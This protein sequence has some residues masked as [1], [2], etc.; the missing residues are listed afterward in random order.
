M[1]VR[2]AVLLCAVSSLA[3]ATPSL[4]HDA[5]EVISQGATD[6]DAH[7]VLIDDRYAALE[8][9]AV[10]HIGSYEGEW[11]GE[12]QSE[13][14]YTGDWHG[15]Y[16]AGEASSSLSTEEYSPFGYS[17]EERA[18]WISQCRAL[19]SDGHRYANIEDDDGDGGIIGGLLGAIAGGI[20]GNRVADGER[21]AG[22]LIGAGVGGLAGAVIGSALDQ[23]DDEVVYTEGEHGFDYCEAYL[24]NYE[25]GYGLPQPAISHTAIVTM[26]PMHGAHGHR[27]TA[28][29]HPQQTYTTMQT[30]TRQYVVVEE[31]EVEVEAEAEAPAVEAPPVIE[32]NIPP[33]PRGKVQTV[34]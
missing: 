20:I 15:T 22:T 33:R 31:V 10:E 2:N 34:S 8:E 7:P 24:L 29:C 14:A 1:S 4:A 6:M 13:D 5:H 18:E 9:G 28:D 30:R 11:D 17:A 27:H 12:W 21:L 19:R 3:V 16:T 23:D 32:R 26:Q 25:R